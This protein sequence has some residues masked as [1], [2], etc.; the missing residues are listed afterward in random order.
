VAVLAEC[1]EVCESVVGWVAVDVV[2]LKETG[3]DSALGAAM[4]VSDS[5]GGAS[6]LVGAAASG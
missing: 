3:A 1:L 6:S 5:G 4:V 2:C